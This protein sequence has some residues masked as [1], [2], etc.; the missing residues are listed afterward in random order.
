MHSLEPHTSQSELEVQRIMHLQMVANELPNTST[1][2]KS[3]KAAFSCSKCA[4][5]SI[6]G[7]EGY[8]LYCLH[9]ILG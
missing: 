1:D 2:K 9:L 8:Q 7:P 3:D 5:E 6:G 4:G